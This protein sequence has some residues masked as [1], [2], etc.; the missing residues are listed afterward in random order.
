MLGRRVGD[1]LV[2]D[3]LQGPDGRDVERVLEGTP[4]EHRPAVELVGV[5]WRP[6]LAAIEL[7]RDV[8][9]QAARGQ[10]REHRRP[11]RTGSA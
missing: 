3:P 8:E 9:E 4:D 10:A 7:G 11:P 1:G 5:A 2:A 6:V